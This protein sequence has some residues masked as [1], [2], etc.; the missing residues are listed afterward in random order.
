M[1]WYNNQESVKAIHDSKLDTTVAGQPR[2]MRLVR[3]RTQA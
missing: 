2:L 3:K 1:L